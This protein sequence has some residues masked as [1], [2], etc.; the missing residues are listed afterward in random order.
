MWLCNKAKCFFMEKSVIYLGYK[1]D[2]DGIHL[3]QEKVK[4]VKDAPELKNVTEHKSFLG[5]LTYYYQIW[6]PRWHTYIN[7]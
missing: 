7:Y 4:V 1:V 2:C 3:L 6:Q 5:L